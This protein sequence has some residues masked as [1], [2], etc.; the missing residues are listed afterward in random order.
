MHI[1]LLDLYNALVHSDIPNIIQDVS[2]IVALYALRKFNCKVP[3]CWRIARHQ[4]EGTTYHTCSKHT[5]AEFHDALIVQHADERPEQH[6]LLSR[7]SHEA[8]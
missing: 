4:V 5:T 6:A 2:G 7:E 3:R 8:V 1:L